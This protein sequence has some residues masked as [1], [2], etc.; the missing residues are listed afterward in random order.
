MLNYWFSSNDDICPDN[1]F[2]SR[3]KLKDKCRSEKWALYL[4]DT[5]VAHARCC[6]DR[7]WG[8]DVQKTADFSAVAV[9]LC[10]LTGYFLGPCTQVHGQG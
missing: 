2:Y 4:L 9:L 5:G 6:E 8:Q 3:F 1:Y 7:A 10:G